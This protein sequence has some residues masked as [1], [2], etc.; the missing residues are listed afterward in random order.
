MSGTKIENWGLDVDKFCVSFAMQV[1]LGL[2]L[3]ISH[4]LHAEAR[5]MSGI[6]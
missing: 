6:N 5:L 4:I 1:E 3:P 2:P